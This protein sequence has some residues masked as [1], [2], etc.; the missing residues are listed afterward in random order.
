MRMTDRKYNQY[1]LRTAT[2]RYGLKIGVQMATY[3]L[4]YDDINRPPSLEPFISEQYNQSQVCESREEL[5]DAIKKL[6]AYTRIRYSNGSAWRYSIVGKDSRI[7]I[8]MSHCSIKPD[9]A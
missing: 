9:D 4:Q 3:I 2:P 6:P 1:F 8:S 7:R 5:N